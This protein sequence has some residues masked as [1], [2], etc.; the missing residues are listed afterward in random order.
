MPEIVPGRTPEDAGRR[1]AA[2]ARPIARPSTLLVR[3]RTPDPA[4]TPAKTLSLPV[5]GTAAKLAPHRRVAPAAADAAP[6]TTPSLAAASHQRPNN[7]L[8][9]GFASAAASAAAFAFLRAK[10]TCERA[11]K[12]GGHHHKLR[13]KKGR[14]STQRRCRSARQSGHAQRPD[15]ALPAPRAARSQTQRPSASPLQGQPLPGVPSP[16][17]MRAGHA[18]WK[19]K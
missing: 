9:D 6:P 18:K 7:Q 2:Q 3:R 15:S 4:P 11:N 13:Q 1:R 5:V 16:E 12:E 17:G 19:W 10:F 8:P 14:L